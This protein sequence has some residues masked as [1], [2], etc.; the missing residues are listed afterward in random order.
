M[1]KVLFILFGML[2]L[3]LSLFAGQV[4]QYKC[5]NRSFPNT[6]IFY[7]QCFVD[8]LSSENVEIGIKDDGG[9]GRMFMAGCITKKVVRGNCEMFDIYWSLFTLSN[10]D[11]THAVFT[12]NGRT[13]GYTNY[14]A[15]QA[16]QFDKNMHL[17]RYSETAR[18]YYGDVEVTF[19]SEGNTLN[20]TIRNA[21]D[22]PNKSI[23]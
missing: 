21:E 6:D 22:S 13:Y 1:K 9:D 5:E 12:I 16:M 17:L 4:N 3:S 10:T 7:F 18:Y 8:N 2:V 19:S 23:M 14:L 15:F 11:S 20:I